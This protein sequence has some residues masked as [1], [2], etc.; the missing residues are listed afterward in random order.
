MSGRCRLRVLAS[1]TNPGSRERPAQA[2]Q[3]ASRTLPCW[4]LVANTPEL[5]FEQVS[6]CL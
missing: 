3:P 5:F 2:S 1:L 6:P 4:S